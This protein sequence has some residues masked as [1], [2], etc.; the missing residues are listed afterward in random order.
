MNCHPLREDIYAHGWSWSCRY[1]RVCICL[2]KSRQTVAL[3]SLV[4]YMTELRPKENDTEEGEDFLTDSKG[5]VIP[6]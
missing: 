3:E 1:L 2:H 5:Q 6:S 4:G